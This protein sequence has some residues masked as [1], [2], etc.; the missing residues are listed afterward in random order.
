MEDSRQQRHRL[1][2]SALF[3]V[4][5]L[6]LAGPNLAFATDLGP[7]GGTGGNPFRFECPK[8]SYIVG[9]QARAGEWIDRIQPICAP[10]MHNANM[11]GPT[12]VGPSFGQSRGGRTDVT[13]CNDSSVKNRAITRWAVYFLRSDSKLVALIIGDCNSVASPR[14][15][16]KG[17]TVGHSTTNYFPNTASHECPFGELVTGNHGRQGLYIDAIGLICRPFPP[18]PPL[19]FETNVHSNAKASSS[20]PSSFAQPPPPSSSA[21]TQMKRSPSMVMPRGIEEKGGKEGNQTV[22]ATA[23]TEKRP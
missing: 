7:D 8:G 6:I 4:S 16:L 13:N 22:D 23:K 14:G 12:T 10:W 1:V 15:P 3:F 2:L 11:F 17:W 21:T 9:F 19:P 20:P 5:G 18:K